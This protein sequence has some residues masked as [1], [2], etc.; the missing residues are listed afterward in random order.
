ME[1]DLLEKT[2]FWVEDIDLHG[3]DLKEVA[4]AA[5]QALGL[6]NHEVMVV[7]VRQGLVAFDILRRQVQAESVAGKKAEILKRLQEV[8]GVII[9]PKAEVHSEGVLGLIALE[10][11]EAQKILVT[12]ARMTSEITQAITRRALVF[13]SGSEVLAG[14]IRDTNSPYIIEVLTKAGFKADFGGILED[15][16]VAVVNRLEES[17]ERGY[18]LIITTGGVG[19]E[20]KDCNIEAILRLDPKAH[21]PWILKFTPDYNR[22]HKEGVR[23]AVGRVGV[24]RLIALPGPH[25]EVRLACQALL[26]GLVQGLDD[27][28]LAEKIAGVLRKRWHERMGKGGSEHHGFQ[29]Y[30]G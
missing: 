23:I 5:A 18:G 17:L 27:A 13:A 28:S 21:T 3:A 30:S 8:P 10:P 4:A 20:D 14:K 22:H 26:E 6:D 24:A 15:D 1:W 2:T 16:L 9:G 19:A 12:S 11:A 7:D 25:E 29:G